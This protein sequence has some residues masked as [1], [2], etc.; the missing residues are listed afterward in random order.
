MAHARLHDT[1]PCPPSNSTCSKVT[2]AANDAILVPRPAEVHRVHLV[3][4]RVWRIYFM[5]NTCCLQLLWIGL[6]ERLEADHEFP[7]TVA[8]YFGFTTLGSEPSS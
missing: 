6:E 5:C 2:A 3:S 1:S 7:R 4:W 8:Q